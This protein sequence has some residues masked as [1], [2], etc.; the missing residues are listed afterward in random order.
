MLK[1]NEG[2]IQD[3]NEIK[4]IQ[5]WYTEAKTDP[6]KIPS[7]VINGIL[8]KVLDVIASSLEDYLVDSISAKITIQ[9]DRLEIEELEIDFSVKPYVKFIKKINSTKSSEI[10]LLLV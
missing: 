4:T 6:E 5:D 2:I 9:K 8:E 3:I 1:D 10:S 7:I